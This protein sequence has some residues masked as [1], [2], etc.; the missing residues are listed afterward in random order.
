MISSQAKE[1]AGQ[2]PG[3]ELPRR[4]CIEPYAPLSD[5]SHLALPEPNWCMATS[6]W[7]TDSVDHYQN[8]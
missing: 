8:V 3:R 2:Q 6:G 5:G 1:S 7:C 4:G